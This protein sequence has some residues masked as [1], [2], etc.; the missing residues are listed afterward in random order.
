MVHWHEIRGHL[1]TT[2]GTKLEEVGIPDFIDICYSYALNSPEHR[3]DMR[4]AMM[5]FM[6]D[7]A[8]EVEE[9]KTFEGFKKAALNPSMLDELDAFNDRLG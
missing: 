7:Y 5:G 4:T 3:A 6:F 9:E 2:T 1:F 8:Q